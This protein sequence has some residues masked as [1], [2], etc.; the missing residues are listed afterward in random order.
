M[1]LYQVLKTVLNKN[2]ESPIPPP[3]VED[4]TEGI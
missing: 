1:N 4:N 2:V 3:V